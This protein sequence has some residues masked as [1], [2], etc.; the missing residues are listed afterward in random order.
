MP[1]VCKLRRSFPGL[2]KGC[3]CDGKTK[4]KKTSG[5]KKRKAT[6]SGGSVAKR[7][8]SAGNLVLVPGTK[9]RSSIVAGPS[10]KRARR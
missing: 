2:A 5:T 1:T 3:T 7:T 4:T 8:R 9:R 10:G 6:D